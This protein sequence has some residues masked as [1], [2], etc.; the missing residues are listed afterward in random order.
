[1][2]A[3]PAK[4]RPPGPIQAWTKSKDYSRSRIEQFP[5]HPEVAWRERYAT[6]ARFGLLCAPAPLAVERRSHG[7]CPR[8]SLS[9]APSGN[10]TA[11]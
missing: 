2:S 3:A 11:D 5:G 8:W 4:A 1:M 7:E 10:C 6:F 9:G